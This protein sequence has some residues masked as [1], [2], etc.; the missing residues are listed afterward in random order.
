MG[1]DKVV[2][3]EFVNI[4]YEVLGNNNKADFVIDIL[5]M[6]TSYEK[7][8]HGT[9]RDFD[10]ST[11]RKIFSGKRNIN[12]LKAELIDHLDEAKFE[13]IIS[14]YTEEKKRIIIDTFKKYNE[15][16]DLDNFELSL[17]QLFVSSLNDSTTNQPFISE[18]LIRLFVSEN[19]G[20]CEIKTCSNL[21]IDKNGK[22]QGKVIKIKDK[23]TYDYDN[24]LFVCE[25]CFKKYYNYRNDDVNKLLLDS[26]IE[27]QKHN[28]LNS[29]VNDQKI[30][31]GVDV[32]LRK[33]AN[34]T[35]DEIELNY[36]PISIANKIY[37]DEP[38]L[39]DKVTLYITNYY[40]IIDNKIREAVML[41]GFNFTVFEYKIKI[42]FSKLD[43]ERYSQTVIFN[44]LVKWLEEQTNVELGPCEAMISYFIQKCEV[45]Y[46]ITK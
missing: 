21:I 44:Q 35:S 13:N 24:L 4:M 22:K 25:S 43:K 40:A 5:D 12:S 18:E 29:I 28:Y 46:D 37:E 38:F 14:D 23:Q 45:F 19:N 11:L 8:G 36:K 34:L 3:Y 2:F 30:E 41:E 32:I 39:K 27:I 1:G 10:R 20:K 26:K 6:V 33:I 15:D 31:D 7:N 16:L 42:L 17:Y 9:Y